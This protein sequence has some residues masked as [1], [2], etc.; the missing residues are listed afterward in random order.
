MTDT[1]LIE[2]ELLPEGVRRSRRFWA[3]D[4]KDLVHQEVTGYECKNM[5][6]YW[7]IPELGYSLVEGKGLFDTE[8]GCLQVL[9]DCLREQ[10]SRVKRQLSEVEYRLRE[11]ET[12]P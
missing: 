6:R 8:F 2:V 3:I 4:P 12:Q 9:A 11:L 1:N 10:K 7:W 5:P